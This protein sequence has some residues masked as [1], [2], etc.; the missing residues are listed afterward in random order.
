MMCGDFFWLVAWTKDWSMEQFIAGVEIQ[1]VKAKGKMGVGEVSYISN[2]NVI[3]Q[4]EKKWTDTRKHL[5]PGTILLPF[6]R[7]SL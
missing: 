1:G 6:T 5:T 7:K 4:V 2:Y 3:S